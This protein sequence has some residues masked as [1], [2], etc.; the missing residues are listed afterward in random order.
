M[1]SSRKKHS[2]AKISGLTT[3]LAVMKINSEL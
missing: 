1:L 2:E 3:V